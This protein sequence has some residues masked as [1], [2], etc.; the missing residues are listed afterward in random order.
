MYRA[1]LD[2]VGGESEWR[3]DGWFRAGLVSEC[4]H[5]IV[6]GVRGW[7]HYILDGV[8]GMVWWAG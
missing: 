8:G 5:C 7:D 6:G 2:D 3:Y 1:G 4:G